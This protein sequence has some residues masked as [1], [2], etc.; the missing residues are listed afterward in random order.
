[1]KKRMNDIW[2]LPTYMFVI[3]GI[4]VICYTIYEVTKLIINGK[5]KMKGDTKREISIY[6]R[7]WGEDW[8]RAIIIGMFIGFLIATILWTYWFICI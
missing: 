3:V 5:I 8:N 6:K 7:F 1:M 4:P 2:M